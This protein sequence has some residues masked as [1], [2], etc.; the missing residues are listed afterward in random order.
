MVGD[1]SNN[2]TKMTALDWHGVFLWNYPD[3]FYPG[4]NESWSN[5][6]NGLGTYW[7]VRGASLATPTRI[8]G[9][10]YASGLVQPL[11]DCPAV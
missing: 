7:E 5:M 6:H 9:G 1:G 3:V 4:Y 8:T 2:V 11:P 10:G